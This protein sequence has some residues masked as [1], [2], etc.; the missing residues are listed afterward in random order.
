MASSWSNQVIRVVIAD[1]HRIV[2]RGI[3]EIL[4]EEG[5]IL[6][7]GDVGTSTQVLEIVREH[8]VDILLLDI[9]MP[10]GGGLEI[11]EQVHRIKPNLRVLILTMYSEE[12]FAVRALRSHAYGY[13]TKQS[14]PEELVE[15]IRTIAKGEKYITQALAKVLVA[16]L[17]QAITPLHKSLSDREFQIL[18]KIASGKTLTDISSE[19]S[20]SIKTISTYRARILAKLKLNNT[21]EIIRYGIEHHLTD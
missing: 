10:D 5:D 13:L 4:E 18:R 6:I 17:D 8:E 9:A 14:A 12:Q 3:K 7:V 16:D 19:L 21:A 15:A 1:D 2:R 11:L 20:L